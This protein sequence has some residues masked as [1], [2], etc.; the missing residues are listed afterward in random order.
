MLRDGFPERGNHLGRDAYPAWAV[1]GRLHP[2]E[3]P[4][5]TPV[6][7]GGH[8]HIEEGRRG[9]RTIAA[10][11]ALACG[12][13]RRAMGTATLNVRDKPNPLDFACGEGPAAATTE[14]L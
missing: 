3:L 9:S 12:T 11:A 8:I 14:V 1:R 10:I 4:S 2:I 5:L 6:G 7:D 13:R